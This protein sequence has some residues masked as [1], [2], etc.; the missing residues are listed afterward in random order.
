EEGVLIGIR[1]TI[2]PGVTIGK[3]SVISAGTVINK[4]VPPNTVVAVVPAKI[5]KKM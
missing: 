5:L 3:G 4:D 2:L 1:V